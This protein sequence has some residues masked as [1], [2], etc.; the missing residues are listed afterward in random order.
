[1]TIA[2]RSDYAVLNRYHC[3]AGVRIRGDIHAVA[4]RHDHRVDIRSLREWA[5][6]TEGA[7]TLSLFDGGHFYVNQHIDALANRVITDV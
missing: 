3:P 2:A 1:M 7:F 5:A 4:G 6:H